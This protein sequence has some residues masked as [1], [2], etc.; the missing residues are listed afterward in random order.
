MKDKYISLVQS[1]QALTVISDPE[2]LLVEFGRKYISWALDNPDFYKAMLLS[3]SPGILEN[4]SVLFKGASKRRPAIRLLSETVKKLCNQDDDT[5][6]LTTQI[7]W[8]TTFGLI[9]RMI[10]EDV[11]DEQKQRLID[12]H[13]IFTVNAVKDKKNFD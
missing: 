13:A 4:S 8:A 1:M 2:T 12:Q 10:I 9:I 11:P 5:V 3:N 6:E 7:I